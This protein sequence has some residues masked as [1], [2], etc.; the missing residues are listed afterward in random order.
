MRLP[1]NVYIPFDSKIRRLGLDPEV[2]QSHYRV[3]TSGIVSGSTYQVLVHLP[4][5]ILV[6]Y[7][8]GIVGMNFHVDMLSTSFIPPW[9]VGKDL[10]EA[11]VV[12]LLQPT[13]PCL[14]ECILGGLV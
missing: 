6:W 4:Y 10:D 11:V 7:L 3:G 12:R 13:V 1:L 5:C 14:A 9:H 8:Y 2:I